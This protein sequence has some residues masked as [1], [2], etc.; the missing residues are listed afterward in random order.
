[1][2][3]LVF[4]PGTKEMIIKNHR[5]NSAKKSLQSLKLAWHTS[6][7]AK[8][9]GNV[10]KKTRLPCHKKPS[11]GEGVAFHS[12]GGCINDSQIPKCERSIDTA[13]FELVFDYLGCYG[14]G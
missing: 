14:D 13:F 11:T 4:P 3:Y 6:T 8:N 5:S 12:G 10:L 2:R 9:S 7:V 1:M